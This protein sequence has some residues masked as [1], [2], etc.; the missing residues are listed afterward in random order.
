MYNDSCK[1]KISNKL[2]VID[3]LFMKRNAGDCFFRNYFF[4]GKIKKFFLKVSNIIFIFMRNKL[5]RAGE[6]MDLS[7]N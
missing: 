5:H 2:N 7:G 6:M 3:E 4:Q 1:D